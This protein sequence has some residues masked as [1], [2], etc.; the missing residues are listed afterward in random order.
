MQCILQVTCF[1][2]ISLIYSAKTTN[3]DHCRLSSEY[4][5]RKL[6][7]V[8]YIVGVSAHLFNVKCMRL[9]NLN[10]RASS[11]VRIYLPRNVNLARFSSLP[12]RKLF[13]VS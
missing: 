3:E 4:I 13:V 7:F 9:A 2:M 8:I 11:P 12:L 1:Q 5:S 10:R 6:T